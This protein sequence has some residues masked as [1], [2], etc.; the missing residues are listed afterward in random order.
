MAALRKG[1][2]LTLIGNVLPSVALPLQS[3]VVKEL[4]IYS[5]MT[6]THEMS[7]CVAMLAAGAVDVEPLINAV[8]PLAQGDAFFARIRSRD[9]SLIKVILAP[10]Q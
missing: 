2:A 5:S 7:R 4:T 1:G 9:R 3:T 6:A 8:V 10:P